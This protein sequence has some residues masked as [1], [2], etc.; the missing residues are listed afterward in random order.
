MFRCGQHRHNFLDM[1]VTVPC[2][3]DIED[4]VSSLFTGIHLVTS[5]LVGQP[6]HLACVFQIVAV[7]TQGVDFQPGHKPPLPPGFLASLK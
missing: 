6:N 7:P 2:V 4:F 5:Q 3:N 1:L